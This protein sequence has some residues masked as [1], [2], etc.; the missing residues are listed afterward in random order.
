MHKII[1]YV[2]EHEGRVTSL[3]L[4]KGGLL[5]SASFDRSLRIWDLTTMKPVA[6]VANAHDTPIQ[7]LEYNQAR[8]PACGSCLFA[9]LL[10]RLIGT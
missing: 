3:A 6:C 5:A 2:Q 4:L 8:A 10:A 1:C 9:C 7:C